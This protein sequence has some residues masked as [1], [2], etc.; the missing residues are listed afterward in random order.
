M[1]SSDGGSDEKPVTQVTLTKPYWLGA[2]EVTQGQ[3]EA[4]MGNN[5]SNFKGGNLPVEGVSYEDAMEFC[6]KLTERERAADRLPEGYAYTLPTEAQWEYACRA[7]TTGDYA[8]N[9][10]AM[11]WHNG[12]S[13]KKTHEVGGK[14]ANAWGLYDMHGNVWE[15]CVDRYAKKLPGGSV[16]DS[17]GP[18]SDSHRAFRGGGWWSDAAYC[19]AAFRGGLSPG[20][21]S[22]YLGFRLALSSVP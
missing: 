21:R 19:R 6:Q 16:S 18:D 13:G 11:G 7:G 4:I 14:Q 22:A 20:I 17:K 9:L 1:G 10:D 2:T 15:W 12:N 3:W 8:S 5:P